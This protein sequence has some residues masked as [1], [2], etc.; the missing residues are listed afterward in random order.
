MRRKERK[1]FNVRKVR[2]KGANEHAYFQ[3]KVEGRINGERDRKFFPFTP[4][5]KA[6]A[7]GYA[8]EKEI[9]ALNKQQDLR[10]APTRLPAADIP[11]AEAA[12]ARLKAAWPGKSLSFAVDWFVARYQEP[13]TDKLLPEIFPL[14]RA[15]KEKEIRSASKTMFGNVRRFVEAYP[16]SKP[17]EIETDQIYTYLKKLRGRP[18]I[19]KGEVRPQPASPKTWNNNRADIH[20][21]F[22][23]MRLFPRKWVT[24]NPVNDDIKTYPFE[25]GVPSTLSVEQ[26]IELMQFV[27]H[28]KEG[29]MVPYYAM[30]LFGG[31]R[32]DVRQ[33]EI[34]RLA[35]LFSDSKVV[36]LKTNLVRV[37]PEI[38][39][40]KKLRPVKL[41]PNLLEWLKAYP[42][43]KY[44]II[45]KNCEEMAGQVRKH[46]ALP[47]DVLRHTHISMYVAK[48]QHMGAAALHAGNTPDVIQSHYYD[49]FTEAEA[50]LFWGITPRSITPDSETLGRIKQAI[51]EIEKRKAKGQK[52]ISAREL[53]QIMEHNSS[54]GHLTPPDDH[55][56]TQPIR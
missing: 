40:T 51:A 6:E 27:A 47:H 49:T 26:C 1:R 22:E 25:Q 28:F 44:P 24:Q 10:S 37:T 15:E 48:F 41:Q 45:P 3:W 38:A 5:G 50:E 7:E 32:P 46:F 14:F 4:Q 36:N 42:A 52:R 30:L 11:D 54:V 35:D 9:E 13:K 33:G 53:Y 34:S 21:F 56:Q 8:E 20:L 17:H 2:V 55:G 18:T 43:K 31:I 12:H 39:K 16:K 23:W 29:K 19:V